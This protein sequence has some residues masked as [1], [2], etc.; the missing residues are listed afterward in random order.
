MPTILR[1][2]P[3]FDHDT[4]LRI[5]DG[6]ALVIRNHQII[7]WVSIAPA[8]C[9]DLPKNARRLPVLLDLGF[10]AE[11]LVR[12]DHIRDWMKSA[13]SETDYPLVGNAIVHGRSA[14]IF[15]ANF[16]IHPNTSGSRGQLS[17]AAPFCMETDT[18]I[19]VCSA[20]MPEFNLPLLGLSALRK[21][22]LRLLV[23]G[24]KRYVSLRAPLQQ[25]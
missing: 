22:R 17:D 5:P 21:N 7:V 19:A 18:G 3:F 20:V 10:N 2:L 23:N 8:T 15:Q 4:S 1:R 9:R 16:W 12:E 13:W 6:P 14:P 25:A 11:L 24:E